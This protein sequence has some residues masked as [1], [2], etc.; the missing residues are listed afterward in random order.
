MKKII[1]FI[2]IVTVA[3]CFSNCNS[4]PA[5]QVVS[6][7]TDSVKNIIL[8]IQNKML[9]AAADSV[10]GAEK[11]ASFCEDSLI[12]SYDGIYMTSAYAV[13]NDLIHG[14]STPP[15]D[16]AFRLYG[17]T[18][19][20]SFREK[21]YE[22]ANGDSVFHDVRIVKTFVQDH[23]TW[24]MAAICTAL[25]PVNYFKAVAEKHPQLYNEYA[26]VYQLNSSTA[27]TVFI[28]D[29]KLYEAFT[30]ENPSID[31]P[32]NDSEYMVK[33]DLGRIIFG[34]DLKGK[35]SYFTLVRYD[36]QRLKAPKVR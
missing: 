16:V 35:I 10:H 12:F 34:R 23:G 21:S 1:A 20:L 22:I 17:N 28:K 19:I 8:D 36:G 11:Y 9:S 24:K 7:N 3:I 27:D 4:N 15:H 5:H 29:G 14:M 6:A 2:T 18:A 26:G 13:S 25:Q 33:D 32:V 31:F 30:G